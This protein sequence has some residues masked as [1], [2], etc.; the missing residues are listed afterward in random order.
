MRFS[1]APATLFIAG[2]L[3]CGTAFAASEYGVAYMGL[4]GSYVWTDDGSTTGDGAYDYNESY[5]DTGYGVAAYMGWV[6]DDS[7][8]LE[9]EGGYRSAAIDEVTIVR[10]DSGLGFYVPGQTTPADGHADLGTAMVNLYYDI[11]LFDGAV[12]PWVGAGLGGAFIDYRLEDPTH[13]GTFE[14]K[15]TTWAFAYQFMAGLTFPVSDGVS[16]S[17]GYRY[18]KT[19]KFDYE[20]AFPE[21]QSTDITQ[22][23]VDVG[24]QFHL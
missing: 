9:I 7:F 20:N 3:A 22:Q 2:A 13:S 8:R 4:R 15:D 17:V 24:L 16:M 23:S 1:F 5:D 21:T 14:G 12:L 6:L 11:H 10:D 18:F 19:E